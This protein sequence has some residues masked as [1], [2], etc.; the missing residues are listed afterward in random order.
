MKLD[1]QGAELD[2]LRGAKSILAY[3]LAIDIEVEFY[4]IY[5]GQPLFDQVFT[6]LRDAGLEFIDFTYIYR[7]SP[8]A[9]NGLG[10]ATFSDALFMRTPEK[11]ADSGDSN[12]IKKFALICTIYERGDL[13]IRLGNA[14]KRTSNTN[15]D[16]TNQIIELGQVISQR[17]ARTQ[18]QLD[19]VTKIIRLFHP[20][21]RAHIVH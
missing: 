6:F 18:R 13:L 11:V 16:T 2:V 4:E 20:R 14:R 9:Y 5:K 3:A 10:Q 21:V 7:W 15:L 12:M 17:N 19:R 1:V 8:N